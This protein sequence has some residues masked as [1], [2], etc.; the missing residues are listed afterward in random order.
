MLWKTINTLYDRA[1]GF[2]TVGLPFLGFGLVRRWFGLLAAAGWPA[3]SG[4]TLGAVPLSGVAECVALALVLLCARRSAPFYDRAG[5]WLGAAVLLAAGSACALA[6]SLM[7]VPALVGVG[8]QVAAAVGSAVLFCVW[9]EALGC[10][11]PLKT[12]IAYCWSMVVCE[13]VWALV[14]VLPQDAAVA[15][16]A[17][18]PFCSIALFVSGIRRIPTVHLPQRGA[19]QPDLRSLWRL[20]VW[21][22]ALSFAFG[23]AD[24]L[25]GAGIQGASYVGKLIPALVILV[26]SICFSSVFDLGVVY[27]FTLPLVVVGFAAL[28]VLPGQTAFAQVFLSAGDECFMVLAYLTV[29][30]SAYRRRYSAV[31]LCAA[32]SL[33]HTLVI[34]FGQAVG[35]GTLVAQAPGSIVAYAVLGF[36]AAFAVVASVLVFREKD[37]YLQ[38]G[39]PRS[40]GDAAKTALLEELAG[41]AGDSKL[42]A[43]EL[44]IALHMM[45]GE[46]NAEIA[47]NLFI[48]PGTVRAHVSKIYAKLGVSTRE[49]FMALVQGA[50]L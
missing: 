35:S 37:F 28:F 49:E 10:L 47:S 9:M 32:V 20:L 8:G 39:T 46:R 31:R 21:I 38:A 19:H 22:C 5:L 17:A 13:A 4:V 14:G 6:P 1:A 23:L 45:E 42:S 15:S 43:R 11:P 44:E 12:A 18:V 34:T 16:V 48:A 7:G 27:R 36:S 29:C 40:D 30:A 3:A 41:K 33:A 25:T 50:A 24:S 26:G 2:V